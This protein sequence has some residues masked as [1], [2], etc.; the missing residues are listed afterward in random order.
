[1]ATPPP[2][3]GLGTEN[4]ELCPKP[5]AM[6]GGFKLPVKFRDYYEVL[7]VPRGA[8]IEEIKKAY[9]RLARKHHPDV[10]PGD[11]SAGERFKEIN[12][13]HEVLSDPEKR[14]R[15]DQLG[16]DWQHGADFTP[17]P[18]WQTYQVNM[19]DLGDLGDLFGGRGGFSDFFTTMFGQQSRRTT[20]PGTRYATRGRD[21]EAEIALTLQEAHLGGKRTITIED[22]A[23]RTQLE[24]NI[25]AGIRD[26]TAIRL[27]GQ[28]GSGTDRAQAGDLYL[29][30]RLQ[31]DP[32]FTLVGEDD[33]Q[34]D[35]PVAPWEAVLG[36]KIRVPTLD[37][38]VEM[39]VPPGSQ[40]D[41]RLRLRGLGL[42]KGAGDR[43][44]QYVRLKIVVPARPTEQ[45]RELLQ[46]LRAV[47][48]FNPRQ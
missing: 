2:D 26:G 36:A 40:A 43:G 22:G 12:E 31:P 29:R 23:G 3:L 45:E 10:N 16:A 25:P 32:V 14:R 41:Q 42:S 5:R 7:G 47:S 27:A 37:G 34:V 13:A 6:Q 30:V 44:D 11:K 8:T 19:E 21:T 28:G 4:S 24:V 1:M 48:R 18:G 33:V 46:K 39:S 17:P 38:S 20:R 9:R 35:L 15:Y